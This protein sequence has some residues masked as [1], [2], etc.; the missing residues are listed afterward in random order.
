MHIAV[1]ATLLLAVVGAEA[2]QNWPDYRGPDHQGHGAAVNLPVEWSESHNVAWKTALPGRGW[3]T[4]VIWGEQIWMTTATEEGRSLRALCVERTS[5]RLLHDVEV[6]HLEKAGE[7]HAQNSHASPSPVI[8]QGRVYIPFGTYGTACLDTADARILWTNQELTLDHQVGPGASPCLYDDLLLFTCDGFDVRYVAALYKADGRLA[9]KTPR[10]GVIDKEGTA[11]KAF[12]TPLVIRALG[13]DVALMPGAEWAHAYDP[14]TGDEL[15]TVKYPGYSNV[16]RPV[17]AHGLV[18]LATG[19]EKP[20]LWAV[21]PEGRGDLSGQVVWKVSKQAPARPS[22]IVVGNELYMV[23]D[24]GL[25]TCLD[26]L[27]GET[28]WTRRLGGNFSGSPILADGKL[29]F[30]SEEG[31]THVLAPGRRFRELAQNQLDGRFMASPVAVG[32]ALFLRTDT[33]LYRLDQGPAADRVSAA[34]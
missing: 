15:W 20:E 12:V 22:P 21:R 6:F 3:S 33:H 34:R 4:P 27:T 26:A 25:L 11:K 13:R 24:T 28:H 18:Y 29:Y 5:G 32:S 10:T 14:R 8:E 2:D 17:Y 16:P 30:C 19:F 9:W 31:K 1:A 23:S 7:I